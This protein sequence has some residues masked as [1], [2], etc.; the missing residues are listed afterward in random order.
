MVQSQEAYA[1]GVNP[2]KTRRNAKPN[3]CATPFEIHN[4]PSATQQGNRLAGQTRPDLSCQISTAVRRAHAS[5]RRAHQ[6]ADLKLTFLSIPP[7]Q[8]RFVLH[9]DYS[10]K[11]QDGIGRTQG[12]YIIGA[13]DPSM[14]AGTRGAVVTTGVEVAQTE[15]RMHVNTGQRGQSFEFGVGTPPVGHVHV[16][17]GFVPPH[18]VWK[19]GTRASSG[20]PPSM[21]STARACLTL[22]QNLVLRLEWTALRHRHGYHSWMPET[23]GGDSSLGTDGFDAWRRSDQRQN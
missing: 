23:D 16:C 17:H 3:D 15:T 14:G 7:E 10:S 20:S 2:T 18:S 19:T 5:V 21:S 1:T 4:H 12:G 9:T 11:D 6:F 13:T 22:Y 8:L